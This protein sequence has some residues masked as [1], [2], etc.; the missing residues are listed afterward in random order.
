MRGRCKC[1]ISYSERISDPLRRFAIN[2]LGEDPSLDDASFVNFVKNRTWV[3]NSI[4]DDTISQL[5]ALYP[6]PAP[7][8][9]TNSPIV[10][11][12]NQFGSDFHFVAPQRLFTDN[13]PSSQDI[14]VFKF[15]VPVPGTP[16]VLGS[17]SQILFRRARPLIT[18]HLASSCPNTRLC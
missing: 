8:P 5:Q 18:D 9:P 2:F 1:A 10:E 12:L 6:P 14:W 11:R 4:S 16:A 17:K 7:V 13:A 3:P 15:N